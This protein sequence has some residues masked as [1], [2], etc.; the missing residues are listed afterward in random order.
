MR[1]FVFHHLLFRLS[2]PQIREIWMGNQYAK[3]KARGRAPNEF[4]CDLELMF[5]ALQCQIAL[6]SDKPLNP[7]TAE[8]LAAGFHKHAVLAEEL[9]YI[10]RDYLIVLARAWFKSAS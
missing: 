1:F 8:R 9:D 2:T 10:T 3:N 5:Y 7:D 6:R 4:R